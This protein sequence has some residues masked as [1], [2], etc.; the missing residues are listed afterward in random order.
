MDM[1][2]KTS[3]PFVG[4]LFLSVLHSR[5]VH[6]GRN[7]SDMYQSA[8]SCGVNSIGLSPVLRKMT[9]GDVSDISGENDTQ[10]GALMTEFSSVVSDFVKCSV[11]NA[12]PFTVCENCLDYYRNVSAVFQKILTSTDNDSITCEDRLMNSDRIQVI[13]QWYNAAQQLW[14]QSHC[15]DCFS[16][17]VDGKGH[18]IYVLSNQTLVFDEYLNR[19]MECIRNNSGVCD[20]HQVCERCVTEYRSLNKFYNGLADSVDNLCMD[21]VDKMNTSRTLWSEHFLCVHRTNPVLSL[22]LFMAVVAIIP[23]LFYI[24]AWHHS[25]RQEQFLVP[26]KRLLN[27]QGSS[28]SVS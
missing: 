2:L 3:A 1:I 18:T 10:C 21:I 11:L 12:R 24:V 16:E 25:V 14:D 7:N 5:V 4:L 26:Q 9:Y 22:F 15:S 8:V 13:L 20:T 23:V 27:V 19:T 28:T 17:A 6:G